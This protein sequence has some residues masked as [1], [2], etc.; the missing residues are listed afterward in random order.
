MRGVIGWTESQ[1][2]L[3]A[4]PGVRDR[5][6]VLGRRIEQEDRLRVQ[7]TWLWGMVTERPALV[8]A[9]AVGNQPLDTT[10]VPGTLVDAELVFFPGTAPLRAL[11]KGRQGAPEPLAE[12][13]GVADVFTATAAYAAALARDPWLEQFPLALGEVLPLRDGDGWL[14]RDSDGRALSIAR[15]F[16]RG[17]EL[18]ALS[19]GKPL[20]LFGEWDGDVLLPLS[21]WAEGQ[22]VR[23]AGAG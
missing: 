1:E 20:D 12:I 17:W 2:V 22:F 16:E 23:L 18:L 11:V 21:V 8:L 13:P 5:W 9:F 15:R 4:Q 6:A 10:L 3:L 14:V 19:G 7:R